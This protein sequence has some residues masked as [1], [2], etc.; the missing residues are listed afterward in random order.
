MAI[1][2]LAETG[3]PV[4]DEI[5]AHLS[6]MGWEHIT[7]TGSYYWREFKSDI[8]VLRPLRTLQFFSQKRKCQAPKGN[9]SRLQADAVFTPQLRKSLSACGRL[10]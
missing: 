9:R 8:N 7:L 5:I 4:P 10:A 3:Q 1:A 6:P 2:A